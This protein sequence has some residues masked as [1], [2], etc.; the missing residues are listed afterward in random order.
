MGDLLGSSLFNLL[1]L[2]AL[3]SFAVPRWRL[4]SRISAAH[5]L[6]AMQS[7]ALTTLAAFGILLRPR[8]AHISVGGL[9]AFVVEI[10]FA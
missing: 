3:D 1:I 7:I 4:F 6:S 2:V 8:V 5:A 10:L 9:G